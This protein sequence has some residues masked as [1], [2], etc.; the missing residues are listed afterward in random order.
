MMSFFTKNRFFE[1]G[2]QRCQKKAVYSSQAMTNIRPA[3][4]CRQ[5]FLRPV[6][7]HQGFLT[8]ETPEQIAHTTRKNLRYPLRYLKQ[9]PPSAEVGINIRG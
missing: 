6:T 7:S 1:I 3:A 4:D 8:R 2:R 9:Q 5:K